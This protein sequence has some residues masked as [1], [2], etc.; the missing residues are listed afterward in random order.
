[1]PQAVN[2]A[3][4]PPGDP[5]V[6]DRETFHELM[7]L[8][9]KHDDMVRAW[10]QFLITI[11]AALAF[12]L[13]SVLTFGH[14]SPQLSA[15]AA[16]LITAIAIATAISLTCIIHRTRRWEKWF[17]RRAC[18][19]QR[20]IGVEIYPEPASALRALASIGTEEAVK[21]LWEALK[22]ESQKEEIR[23]YA[24]KALRNMPEKAKNN[25]AG[26]AAVLIKALADPALQ[27]DA[28]RALVDIWP[29]KALEELGDRKSEV[30][31]RRDEIPRGWGYKFWA[32]V[33]IVAVFL[34][35]V[36][37]LSGVGTYALTKTASETLDADAVSIKCQ[38][39]TAHITIEI[40]MASL[41]SALRQSEGD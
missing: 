20:R 27:Y 40:P 15:L 21:V 17:G 24:A 11:E 35:G 8:H 37:I 2:S 19:L 32:L 4:A 38:D 14:R 26:S 30:W 33:C 39:D 7:K 16:A 10:I 41:E 25:S 5:H 13:W 36:L 23:Q 6:G 1:M 34:L 18:D 31:K 9:V 29:D 28:I 12:A 3:T 22:D